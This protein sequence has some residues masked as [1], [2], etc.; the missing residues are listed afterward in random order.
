VF[1]EWWREVLH[2]H[3][4]KRG[5]HILEAR[6]NPNFWLIFSGLFLCY[7]SLPCTCFQAVVCWGLISGS[8]GWC[9]SSHAAREQRNTPAIFIC[10]H[11][12]RHLWCL[13]TSSDIPWALV[14]V[15]R[16]RNLEGKL[17]T[18][19]CFLGCLKPQ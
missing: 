8:D 16:V 11:G 14:R 12:S 9:D 2:M 5:L 4:R 15:V 18:E 3:K 13:S 6:P 19:V 7:G 10:E 1:S 17:P